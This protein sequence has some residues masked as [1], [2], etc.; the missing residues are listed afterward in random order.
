MVGQKKTGDSYGR[1]LYPVCH[2]GGS[3]QQRRQMAERGRKGLGQCSLDHLHAGYGLEKAAGRSG[4]N[5]TSE[6]ANCGT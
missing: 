4:S 6:D 3:H 1:P 2:L 5:G